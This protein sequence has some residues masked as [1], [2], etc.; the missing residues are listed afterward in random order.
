MNTTASA[1]DSN[2]R[3]IGDVPVYVVFAKARPVAIDYRG[4]IYIYTGKSGESFRTG[5][6]MHELATGP[7]GASRIWSNDTATRIEED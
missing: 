1:T 5:E 6:A 7:S 4:K 3:P 2:N